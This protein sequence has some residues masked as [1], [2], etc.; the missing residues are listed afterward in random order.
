L[1]ASAL[2]FFALL[3][4]LVIVIYGTVWS[5]NAAALLLFVASGILV[6]CVAVGVLRRRKKK[7]RRGTVLTGILLA[8]LLSA[9][10]VGALLRALPQPVRD[11]QRVLGMPLPACEKVEMSEGGYAANGSYVYYRVDFYFGKGEAAS[12]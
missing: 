7:C 8:A 12:F 11:T 1:A 5:A 6:A 4:A 9:G 3:A 2:T 10:G